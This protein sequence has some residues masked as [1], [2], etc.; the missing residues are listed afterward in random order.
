[1]TSPNRLLISDLYH[2]LR[3]RLS[4]IIQT[5]HLLEQGDSGR[6]SA[7]DKQWI[8]AIASDAQLQSARIDKIIEMFT[9]ELEKANPTTGKQLVDLQELLIRIVAICNEV[10]DEDTADRG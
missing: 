8:Q 3:G 9:V 7:I 6:F 1:M 5:V 2:G 10:T 4:T